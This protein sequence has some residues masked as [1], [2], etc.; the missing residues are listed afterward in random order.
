VTAAVELPA[1]TA[2]S[3][4]EN[5]AVGRVVELAS[6]LLML[7]DEHGITG[8]L[9]VGARAQA[10]RLRHAVKLAVQ[11]AA[12]RSSESPAPTASR[13]RRRWPVR[14]PLLG[15]AREFGI[16]EGWLAGRWR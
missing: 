9:P 15:E 7:L 2:A 4:A 11:T 10:S 12:A 13:Q 1:G 16:T 6:G 3:A 8:R 14:R 5:R